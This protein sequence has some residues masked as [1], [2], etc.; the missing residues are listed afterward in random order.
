MQKK[1][2]KEF[3]EKF[4]ALTPSN[5]KYIIAIQEALSFAQSCTPETENPKKRKVVNNSCTKEGYWYDQQKH[6]MFEDYTVYHR[7]CMD[8]QF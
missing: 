6:K 1:E 2:E 4:K 3:I 7:L 8:D 5:Q